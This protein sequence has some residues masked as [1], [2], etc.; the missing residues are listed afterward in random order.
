MN[1]SG[2]TPYSKGTM[3]QCK[4]CTQTGLYLCFYL[5]L[6]AP[7]RFFS[8]KDRQDVKNARRR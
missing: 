7:Q 8:S 2:T 4:K 6:E 5:I 3:L 1:F